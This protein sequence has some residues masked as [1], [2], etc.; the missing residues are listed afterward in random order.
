MYSLKRLFI[1]ISIVFFVFA[2]TVVFADTSTAESDAVKYLQVKNIISEHYP[3]KPQALITRGEFVVWALKNSGFSGETSGK[4]NFTD[5]DE[6]DSLFPYVSTASEMGAL[7]DF[8]KTFKENKKITRLEALEILFAVEGFPVTPVFDTPK[9]GTGL[10]KNVG[11]RSLLLQ[12]EELGLI[13]ESITGKVS[14]SAKITQQEAA[15]MLYTAA[16]IKSQSS[17]TGATSFPKLN[18]VTE[19]VQNNFLYPE[20]INAKKG[21]EEA[22]RGYLYTLDDPYTT[23][24]TKEENDSFTKALDGKSEGADYEFSGIGV[25]LSMDK[26]KNIIILKVFPNTPAERQGL[27]SG[28]MIT[29]IEGQN[30]AG[31]SIELITSKIKGKTGTSVSITITRD[32]VEKNFSVPREKITFTP[33]ENIWSETKENILW[34]HINSFGYETLSKFQD[35]LK[36]KITDNTMGMIIDL[37]ENPGGLMDTALGMLG[38]VLPANTVGI[39]TLSHGY[40][41]SEKVVGSGNYTKIP[42]VVFQNEYSASASEIFSGAIQDAKRGEIIGQQSFGKGVAQNLIPFA[43]GS[44]L[45]LTVEEFRTPNGNIVHGVGITPDKKLT[46]RDNESFFSAAKESFKKLPR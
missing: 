21:E 9:E 33:E 46:A 23:Y 41:S 38:E 37:R 40:E 22:I 34:I 44:T 28:D 2:H 35:I 27:Q 16:V 32:G 10:P 4:E 15:E 36:T 43:D 7:K 6:K 13:P 29:A 24:F 30:I 31:E 3:F 5:I 12:A 14:S 39:T 8:G 11:Q 1:S 42:L 20:R 17:T 19:L 45:K 26:N 18:R 25:M